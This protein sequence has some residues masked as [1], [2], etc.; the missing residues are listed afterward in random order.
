MK[1]ETNL[2][3]V[4]LALLLSMFSILILC[5]TV[6]A[7]TEI[8]LGKNYT[9]TCDSAISCPYGNSTTWGGDWGGIELTDGIYAD[10]YSLD[11]N[12]TAFGNPSQQSQYNVTI[13]VNLTQNYNI[14]TLNITM[15][16]YTGGTRNVSYWCGDSALQPH[17]KVSFTLINY[18]YYSPP[19]ANATSGGVNKT[20]WQANSTAI[21][22]YARVRVQRLG[23]PYSQGL[24][25]IDEFFITGDA[26]S[27]SSSSSS[28]ST[29]SSTESS[30]SS[31]SSSEYSSSSY[32]SSTSSSSYA[33]STSDA[34]YQTSSSSASSSSQ[35]SSSSSS[36]LPMVYACKNI[37]VPY[38]K[39]TQQQNIVPTNIPQGGACINITAP[40]TTYDG[41]GYSISNST[42]NG[43]AVWVQ[44]NNVTLNNITAN[45]GAH[46]TAYQ[47]AYP[48]YFSRANNSFV[49]NSTLTG[50]W[51]GL[52]ILQ[53]RNVT[54]NNVTSSNT[55]WGGVELY[56]SSY[57]TLINLTITSNSSRGIDLWSSTDNLLKNI[58]IIATTQALIF[59]DDCSNNLVVDSVINGSMYAVFVTHSMG[60]VCIN[61]TLLNVSYLSTNDSTGFGT[62]DVI[63][64]KWYFILQVNDTVGTGLTNANVTAWDT[65]GMFA[66]SQLAVNTNRGP[67]YLPQQ[68]MTEYTLNGTTKTYSTNYTINA[69]MAGYHQNPLK[70]NITSNQ[71]LT[72]A[73]GPPTIDTIT[74]SPDSTPTE[75]GTQVAPVCNSYKNVT[76]NASITSNQYSDITAVTCDV[77][78]TSNSVGSPN[79]NDVVLTATQVNYT[80]AYWTGNVSMNYNVYPINFTVNCTTTASVNTTTKQDSNAFEYQ[81]L[82][83]TALFGTINYG[84]CAPQSTC[85]AQEPLNIS[86][87]GNVLINTTITGGTQ[88]TGQTNTSQ[89]IPAANQVRSNVSNYA[90]VVNLTT[91]ALTFFNYISVGAT[92]V[93]YWRLATPYP[94]SAQ[95]FNGTVSIVSTNAK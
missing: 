89:T 23:Q 49:Y 36:S 40:N 87:R 75:T 58:N 19:G 67:G 76:I 60:G 14:S 45:V 47:F 73:L 7:T 63:I 85:N 20:Q 59:I 44:N 57:C 2:I 31:T 10:G 54:V 48:I 81:A 82:V 11:T 78:N 79:Y 64:R 68:N 1:Q 30:S 34:S 21:C 33:S 80:T 5:L 12:Y 38:V 52:Y 4:V 62:G 90:T 39:Y 9:Y 69:T 27:S 50:G 17:D 72:V 43:N 71:D 61:N 65:A 3:A 66:F 29:S 8:G 74:Y 16:N 28:S 24:T 15:Y 37:T 18:S 77:W 42:F 88:M 95:N 56:T 32:A 51:Y 26:V 84:S 92:N 83:C 41:K 46:N 93:S 70:S 53:S 91:S 6:S 13:T 94:L 22:F 25:A 86:N 55:P 35:A